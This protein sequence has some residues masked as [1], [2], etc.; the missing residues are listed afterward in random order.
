[1]STGYDPVVLAVEPG[2]GSKSLAAADA[3]WGRLIEGGFGRSD[4]VVALG[5]GVV[6]DLAGFVAA[7]FHRGMGLVQAP[8]TLLAHVASSIGG[9]V[10]I[11]HRLGKNL[12]GA[13]H[14]PLRVVA[15]VATLATLPERERWNGVAEVVKTALVLDAGFFEELEMVLG[16]LGRGLLGAEG[17]VGVGG[18]TG[19]LQAGGGVGGEGGGGGRGADAAELRAHR[20]ARAGGRHRT[21][22]PDARRGGGGRHARRGGGLG[23]SRP[24]RPGGGAADRGGA[25]PVSAG[26][27]RGPSAARGGAGG[28]GAGQESA[29][30][31][32]PL[33][34]PRRDRPRGSPAG[35]LA[36][37]GQPGSERGAGGAVMG[38]ARPPRP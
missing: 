27:G 21:R 30:R 3:L 37:A 36:G 28:D 10:A 31:K 32:A 11:D 13:F 19:G 7:T 2:E 34:R 8:T 22:A 9:K 16:L 4:T 29:W 6:G 23:P 17:W 15:D 33:H 20:G 24:S 12:V 18:G 5:G 1:A 26:P 25:R 38:G 35:A 14:P